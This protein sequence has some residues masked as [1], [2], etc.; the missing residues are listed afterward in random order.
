MEWTF[1]NCR[2]LLT[3]VVILT[4]GLC[5]EEQT[6][7]KNDGHNQLNKHFNNQETS[8][9]K[10]IDKLNKNISANNAS[11]K[12]VTEAQKQ[13]ISN[14]SKD[15]PSPIPIIVTCPAVTVAIIFFIW[16]FYSTRCSRKDVDH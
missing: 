10:V 7:S 9:N 4:V 16:S 1:L 11:R 14:R 15:E 8:S 12:T 6:G 5:L 3:C 2:I 13:T